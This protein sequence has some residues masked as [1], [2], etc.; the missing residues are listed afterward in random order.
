MNQ[1]PTRPSWTP[2]SPVEI[3]E[4]KAQHFSQAET[5]YMLGMAPDRIIGW[6]KLDLIPEPRE[7]TGRG[8]RRKYNFLQLAHLLSMRRLA[9]WGMPLSEAKMFSE[10]VLVPRIAEEFDDVLA[11]PTADAAYERAN[12]VKIALYDIS[13][14]EGQESYQYAVFLLDKLVGT[15]GERIRTE[16]HSEP[17]LDGWLKEQVLTDVLVLVPGLLALDLGNLMQEAL[18][19][20]GK[21]D[22]RE[23]LR[24]YLRELKE[25]KKPPKSLEQT[26]HE[27]FAAGLRGETLPKASK[28]RAKRRKSPARA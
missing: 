17:S 28:Q 18:Q 19:Q 14:W 9:K 12:W 8:H 25:G 2:L 1:E 13:T 24:Q 27:A 23:E 11:E 15:S 16:A 21:R 22:W 7:V 3:V 20:R 4:L 26:I 6:H 5:A 10:V